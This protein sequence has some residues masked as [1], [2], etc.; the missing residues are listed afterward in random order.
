MSH[1]EDT[2][3]GLG[4]GRG[5][6]KVGLQA[7]QKRFSL[8]MCFLSKHLKRWSGSVTQV[9]SSPARFSALL[10]TSSG[11]C[12]VHKRLQVPVVAG[13]AQGLNLS[14][15]GRGKGCSSCKFLAPGSLDGAA[16]AHFFCFHISQNLLLPVSVAKIILCGEFSLLRLLMSFLPTDQTPTNVSS[17]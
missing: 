2:R 3:W 15:E 5:A 16:T 6:A 12:S 10:Q 14:C 8:K 1:N 11:L 7:G 13:L 4:G 9:P 17:S